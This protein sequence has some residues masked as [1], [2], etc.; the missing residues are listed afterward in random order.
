MTRN[1]YIP[2]ASMCHLKTEQ[3]H[4]KLFNSGAFTEL[5]FIRIWSLL[6]YLC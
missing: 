5:I 1:A 2:I 6:F 3:L 4:L